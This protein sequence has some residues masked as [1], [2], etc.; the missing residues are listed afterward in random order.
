[1]ITHYTDQITRTEPK[2]ELNFDFLR[3]LRKIT[4]LQRL[5]MKNLQVY[6]NIKKEKQYA[7]I[8]EV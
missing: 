8:S 7:I 1:M 5:K 6:M 4:V 2:N 3:E